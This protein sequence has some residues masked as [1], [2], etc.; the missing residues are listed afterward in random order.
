MFCPK[1]GAQNDDGSKFC[2]GCGGP[3]NEAA[4]E[5]TPQ[6]FT[7]PTPA[8]PVYTPPASFAPYEAPIA[9][10]K[11]H[12]GIIV[13]II[14]VLVLVIIAACVFLFMSKKGDDKN[15]TTDEITQTTVL[16]TEPQ[17]TTAAEET[18]VAETATQPSEDEIR[19]VL[20][21]LGIANWNGS[22]DSL[23]AE[24]KQ[25]L[26]DY[27]KALG[28]DIQISDNGGIVVN[29]S[30]G[31]VDIF[32]GKWPDSALLTDVPKPDFGKIFS[33]EVKATEVNIILSEVTEA[34]FNDFI[35]KVKAA[36]FNNNAEE[37]NMYGTFSYSADNNKGLSISIAMT[38]VVGNML[39]ISVTSA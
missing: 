27:Y 2:Q 24:Q 35:S 7:P 9:K 16:Q 32:G 25:A 36:G 6:Q 18:T 10:K 34:N 11:G 17:D 14:L 23:T 21:G 4:N 28:E 37:F 19:N 29:N 3:L 20:N 22:W 1:C 38:S 15:N 33:S 30:E 13:L 12:G 8:A 5:N 39:T 31:T 26:E